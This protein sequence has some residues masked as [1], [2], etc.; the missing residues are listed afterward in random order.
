MAVAEHRIRRRQRSDRTGAVSELCLWVG[1][2]TS[3]E[4][5]ECCRAGAPSVSRDRGTNSAHNGG[6]G[7]RG[8]GRVGQAS[9]RAPPLAGVTPPLR[10]SGG[11]VL[12]EIASRT[13]SFEGA[14]VLPDQ[15]LRRAISHSLTWPLLRAVRLGSLTVRKSALRTP[16]RALRHALRKIVIHSHI[17]WNFRPS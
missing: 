12:A 2:F 7:V 10:S 13:V 6:L 8:T 16:L 1:E 5:I 15:T 4:L 17:A 9:E 11:S 14:R 3:N